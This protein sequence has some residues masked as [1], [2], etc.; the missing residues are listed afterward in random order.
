MTK[1][2]IRILIIVFII[3]VL[4]VFIVFLLTNVK[5]EIDNN[6][7]EESDFINTNNLDN[8]KLDSEVIEIPVVEKKKEDIG[9]LKIKTLAKN[10]TERY[11][12]WSTDN[13][14]ENF[15]SAEIYATI[16]MK[17][18]IEDFILDNEK[19]SDDYLDFYGVTTKA[20][21]V[22]ILTFNNTDASL[23]VSV[24]QI[25]TLGENLDENISYKNLSLELIKYNDDWLVDYAEW[26]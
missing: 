23:N 12:T 4:I 26:E 15:K 1:K 14:D 6:I 16:R 8:N 21:N 2:Q 13:K 3:I 22:K 24:Q 11:G 19:L 20:L 17:Q 7:D 25:E 18:R 9:E 10:F 5:E